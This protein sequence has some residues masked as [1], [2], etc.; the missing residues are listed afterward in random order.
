M[1][2]TLEQQDA[3]R[4][5]DPP[6]RRRP[7]DHVAVCRPLRPADA[8]AVG[9]RRGPR[10]GRPAGR[11]GRAQLRTS[12]PHEK[13]Q[14][15][16][17]F[18]ECGHHRRLHGPGAR[19]LHR[20]PQEPRPGAGRLRAVLGGR[21]RRHLQPGG[22][23]G[24]VA[25]PRA[26]HAGAAGHV[27]APRRPAPTRRG[28]R[29]LAR[30]LSPDR[31]DA[32][33]RRRDRPAGGKVRVAEWEDG[34][35][36]ILQVD[37]R[38]RF[39]TNMGFANFVTAAVDSADPR[40]KGSCMVILEESD[41]GI[42][43]RG[44]PDEEAGPPALLDPRS[45][46]QPAGAGQ[47][48]H[49]RLHGQGRRHRPP[50]QPRRDHRGGLPPHARDGR[51]HDRGQA[52]LGGRAGHPLPARPLPRRREHRAGLAALRAGPAA[53][54]GRAAPAGGHLGHRRGGASLGFAAARLF[55]ELDPLERQKDEVLAAQ[56]IAGGTAQMR[57]FRR[58][59][60]GR[61]GVPRSPGPTGGDAG[62]PALRR[63]SARTRWCSSSSP[64][65]WP[66][67]FCPACKLWNTG[68]GANMMREAVSLMG[69]YG[70][71]EDCPGFLGQKWMDAQLEATY[72][73]PEAVQ[74]RQLSVTMTNELF[75][76][77]FRD[78]IAEM[79]EIA[80]APPGTGA[81]T[82]ATA[83]E[84][85]LWTL[86]HLQEATDADGGKLYHSNRQGVTFPLADALCWLLAA[87]TR[88]ST[89]SSWRPRGPRTRSWPRACR[90]SWASSP[91]S[92]TSRR[93]APP[94]KWAA[95]AP[96]WCTAT[97]ATRP[98]MAVRGCGPDACDPLE[99]RSAS[100]RSGATMPRRPQGR[101]LRPVR[102][103]GGVRPAAPQAGR[104]PHRAPPG[105]GPRRRGA[106][107][108]HD[109]RGAGLPGYEH[110][111]S[112]TRSPAK[113]SLPE[114]GPRRPWTWTSSASASGRPWAA[115]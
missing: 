38:G 13:A 75:L 93:R 53:E 62:R 99:R 43:D 24:P 87:A 60:E 8:G 55:D 113:A 108:G 17:A 79:R 42:F 26:R 39:I 100:T 1:E 25:H 10:P 67:C 48:H 107:Q 34:K 23:P 45:G 46:L 80:A 90:A 82:L 44:A 88:S 59:A 6:G 28:P 36:P 85:W 41:P 94:A 102:R 21:R 110:E 78:W 51:P 49:R 12:G 63:R 27:H 71:T 114:H 2:R 109:P 97:I 19:R 65:R 101:P 31:A 112:R 91:T 9:A 64:T 72:E 22:Q 105:Q 76:A 52:A 20:G 98:G 104:L 54:G 106:D 73:G 18:D 16:T 77:Q 95:S 68:H 103:A 35:E 84:L 66:T 5:A 40:I 33:R 11:R 92:A 57:A 15:L 32:L 69:G 50:L 58:I 56:G 7:P 81:C 29:D 96:S 83:M 74:R 30:A 86:T 111:T 61:P 89:S 47:P 3:R 70:I 37:K 115:S 14:L 4:P